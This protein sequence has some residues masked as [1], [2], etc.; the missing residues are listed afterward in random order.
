MS[1]N[2]RKNNMKTVLIPRAKYIS[3]LVEDRKKRTEVE[4]TLM[5]VIERI[6]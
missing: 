6:E 5:D 4:Q 2:K 3:Y 1:E